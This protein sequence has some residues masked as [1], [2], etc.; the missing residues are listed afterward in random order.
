MNNSTNLTPEFQ[1]IA[2]DVG[3]ETQ[4]IETLQTFG[5]RA[6]GITRTK[7]DTELVKMTAEQFRD[8]C[9]TFTPAMTEIRSQGIIDRLLEH[10]QRRSPVTGHYRY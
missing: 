6:N 5:F 4:F 8:F 3:L 9:Q 10:S 1:E 7:T 2:A